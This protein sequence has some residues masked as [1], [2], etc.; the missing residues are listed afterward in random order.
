MNRLP[1]PFIL[2]LAAIMFVV[3]WG[4]GLG[5]IFIVL[6]KKTSLDQ[7]GAVIIG[8]ALVVMVPLIASL[9]ALPKRS[10]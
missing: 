10:N 3:I 4:G 2:P 1:F 8:M 6:D 7:W 5:V 9:I